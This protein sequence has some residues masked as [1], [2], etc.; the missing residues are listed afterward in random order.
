MKPKL[1]LN[2]I[3]SG[4]GYARL[5]QQRR[6]T[7]LIVAGISLAV[8][9]VGMLIFG[10][11]V[12]IRSL[13]EERTVF[14]A[15]PPIKTYEPRKLEHQVKVSKRQRSSSRPAVMPR[16]VAMKPSNFAL[17]EIKVDPKVVRTSFQP[18]FKAITGVGL[19]AGLGTGYGL[20]GFGQGVSAFDFFGIR[21][22]G[23]KIMICV[24]VSVSMIEEERGGFDGFERVKSRLRS[25]VDALGEKTL[26]N[27]VAFADA[28]QTF[29]DEMVPATE[30][31][32]RDAKKFLQPYNTKSNY[33]L[34][35]GNIRSVDLGLK[36][37]GGTTRLDLALTAAFLQGADTILIISDGVPRVSKSLTGDQQSAWNAKLEEWRKANA[38]ALEAFNTAAA[39]MEYR[40]ER[41]WVPPRGA[42]IKEGNV[43]G[44][45]EGHF[46]N[47]RTPVRPLPPRP[48]PPGMPDNMRWWSLE[49]FIE[50]FTLL[51]EQCYVKKGK[52]PPIVHT[53]GY[54]IDKEGGDFLQAF[55]KKYNGSYRRVGKIN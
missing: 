26:F 29:K 8:H 23:E 21:G 43:H 36:A 55:T 25:V 53:I 35:S 16:L 49:D 24:D 22:R 3:L 42:S 47:R 30:N 48:Q 27:V 19:G 14:T 20:G 7:L 11:W 46:E 32:K 17:P 38:A 52:K 50:H 51:H 45:R 44:A 41:V 40:T 13:I 4:W 31:N 6:R 10:S 34:E 1:D 54:A 28:G 2:L 5:S 12:V 37:G 33:G 9:L 39:G 15:P 18:K